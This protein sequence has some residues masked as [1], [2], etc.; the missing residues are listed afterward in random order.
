MLAIK[1]GLTVFTGANYESTYGVTTSTDA[2]TI[3]FVTK[4]SN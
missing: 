4:G 2:L 1:R 3:K